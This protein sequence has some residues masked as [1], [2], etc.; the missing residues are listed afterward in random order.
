MIS[1]RNVEEIYICT[2]F[3]QYN[4]GLNQQSRELRASSSDVMSPICSER[5]SKVI[6]ETCQLNLS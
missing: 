2:I 3:K 4:G 1:H 5:I 6:H